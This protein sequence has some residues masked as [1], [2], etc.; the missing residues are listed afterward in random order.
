MPDEKRRFTRVPFKVKAEMT[1]ND[2]LYS[3]VKINNLSVGGCLL[4]IEAD[5]E[6]GTK[7]RLK[8]VL[9][10]ANSK[11][12]VQVEGKIIRCEPEAVAIKFT[13]IEP[14]SLFH[15]QNIIR[16][17]HPDTDKVEQEISNYP[18]LE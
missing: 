11:L 8:I 15:L 1:V 3:S 10:G 2:V 5:V 9:S 16:Y 7:C 6:T 13:E 4:P 18:G 17:N 14:D 12:S